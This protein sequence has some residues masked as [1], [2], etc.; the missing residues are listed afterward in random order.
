MKAHSGRLGP[1]ESFGRVFDEEGVFHYQCTV[2]WSMAGT[3]IVEAQVFP[4]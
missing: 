4:P 2:H 1:G 3:V